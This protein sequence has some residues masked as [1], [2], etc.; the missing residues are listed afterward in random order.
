MAWAGDEL[1]TLLYD[2]ASNLSALVD[3]VGNRT[4]YAYDALNRA[5]QETDHPDSDWRTG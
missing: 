5:T 2:P 3:P 1:T 4:T